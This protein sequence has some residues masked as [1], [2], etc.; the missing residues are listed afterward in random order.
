[1]TVNLSRREAI[2]SGAALF[3]GFYLPQSGNSLQIVSPNHEILKPNAWVRITP[4]NQIT[5]LTE[6][7]ELGQ[8]T[9]TADVMML[10]DELEV[11]WSG[12]R[13]EQAPTDPTVYKH[14]SAG[15]SHGT[16]STYLPMRK[17]GAQVRELLLVA[18]AQEW[19]VEKKECR[20]EK[21]VVAHSPTGRRLSYGELVQTAS[22]IPTTNLDQVPLKDPKDFS[23]IG[24][25]M[26]RIDIPGKVDGSAIFGIDV[27]LP[28]MLFAVIARPPCFG[29][30]VSGYEDGAA[31]ATPGVRAVVPVSAIGYVPEIDTN[32]NVAGGVAVVADSTWAALQGRK[33]L[34][35]TWEK[36]PGPRESTASLREQLREKASG[37]PTVVTAERGNV[38]E[39][40]ANSASTVEADYEMPFQAH[41]TMETM[42]TT[43]CVHEDG[44]I[45]VW[46][47]T[48]IA[49]IAQ[50]EI[51]QLAGIPPEK[52]IVNLTLSGGSFGRRYQWDYLAEAYLVAKQIKGPV[53][54]V[55]SRGKMI[56]STTSTSSIPIKD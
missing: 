30:R 15:A 8:G 2:K 21:G 39:G 43:V 31:K 26:R 51:A 50:T 53:Q 34:K 41:A 56:F 33:A 25:P 17:A 37:P 5:I 35:I 23:F 28:G 47:P 24:K 14:L 13:W 54:L 48:Q 55:W 3:L 44:R 45:E 1:V 20:A 40:I 38:I 11:E 49:A 12:I 9:R 36:G 18:A 32:L 27:R 10:A 16:T 7:P 4:D 46:S 52:V 19:G 42:N 22:T 6:V 29:G